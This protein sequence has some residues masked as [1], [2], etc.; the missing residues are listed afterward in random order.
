MLKK[1]KEASPYQVVID[2]F[3][4]GHVVDHLMLEDEKSYSNGLE[5][6]PG[7]SALVEK[8]MPDQNR[9]EKLVGMEFVLFAMAE[10]SLIG[11]SDLIRGVQ[12]KDQM[13]TMLS[14]KFTGT[15]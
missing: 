11:K 4:E 7:L 12:F 1:K 9:N 14:D 3:A 8:Y 15:D 2:W 5:A 13:G 10:H 6:I